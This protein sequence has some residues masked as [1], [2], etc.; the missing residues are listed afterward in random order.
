[1]TDGPPG[2]VG[3]KPSVQISRLAPRCLLCPAILPMRQCSTPSGIRHTISRLQIP[4]PPR[5]HSS[6]GN[7]QA[8][9]TEKDS[10]AFG[11]ACKSFATKRS[12]QRRTASMTSGRLGLLPRRT[13]YRE[14]RHRHQPDGRTPAETLQRPLRNR[15]PRVY[16]DSQAKDWILWISPIRIL[17]QLRSMRNRTS[18]TFFFVTC[19]I[20]LPGY[21]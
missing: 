17:Q 2:A 18:L 5:R 6:G 14:V 10:A 9:S 20:Q 13:R 19:P 16:R 8:G 1:M 3:R 4:L 7:A 12:T 11:R 21:H 15:V